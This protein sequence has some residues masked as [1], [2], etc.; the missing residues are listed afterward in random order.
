MGFYPSVV[1]VLFKN[2][3]SRMQD[4]CPTVWL[5]GSSGIGKSRS[6]YRAI[7]E[8]SRGVREQHSRCP[9]EAV[10]GGQTYAKRPYLAAGT[11]CPDNNF[12]YHPRA[13]TVVRF[14]VFK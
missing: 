9:L 2:V 7:S 11:A 12:A 3:Y 5:N 4:C 8:K 1:I 10:L 14:L 13:D 6:H